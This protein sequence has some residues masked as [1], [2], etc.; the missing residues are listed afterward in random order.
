MRH[1]CIINTEDKRIAD[2]LGKYGYICIPTEKS[3]DVSEPISLH[4]DVLYLKIAPKQL[5]I[6]QCQKNNIELLDKYG[7]SITKIKLAPGYKTECRL[8]VAVSEDCVVYNPDTSVSTECFAE[9]K[10]L[11]YVKQGYTKCST[12]VLV[13]NC[14]ITEDEG[15]YRALCSSG[16]KCLLITKGY[17][18]LDGYD[19]GFIGGASAYLSAA[20][21]LLFFGDISKHPDFEKIK[22]FCKECNCDIKWIEN[23][24]LTDIGGAVE[25]LNNER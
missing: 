11:I 18:K 19:Y 13:N 25:V 3:A 17:V 21:K 24:Q 2:M 1:Y 15:I 9:N 8:N 7:Y 5:F 6:S 14:F 4:A 22:A 10:Q 23:M 16:R 20:K 12:I